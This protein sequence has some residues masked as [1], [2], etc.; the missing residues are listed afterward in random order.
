MDDDFDYPP[1]DEQDDGGGGALDS[2]DAD[3]DETFGVD[4]IADDVEYEMEKLA[5][6]TR[7]AQI[8]DG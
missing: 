5:T 7:S 2:D 8:H 1:L 6:Q 4:V 3:N